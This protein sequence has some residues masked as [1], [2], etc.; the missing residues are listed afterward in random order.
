[1]Y[2]HV[3]AAAHATQLEAEALQQATYVAKRHVR[4]LAAGESNQELALV[5]AWTVGLAWDGTRRADSC[6]LGKD[7]VQTLSDRALSLQTDYY[8]DGYRVEIGDVG[9]P[10]I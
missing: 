8:L 6:R 7:A 4:Q 1:M 9:R 2:E 10:L 3:M 5:H